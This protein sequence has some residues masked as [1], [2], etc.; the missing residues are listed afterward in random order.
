[1]FHS[2]LVF[3]SEN[4]AELGIFGSILVFAVGGAAYA[5]SRGSSG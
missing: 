2:L 4:G 5:A 1:M 3:I